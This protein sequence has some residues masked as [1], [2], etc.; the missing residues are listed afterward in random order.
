M[1]VVHHALKIDILNLMEHAFHIGYYERD[2]VF[3]ISPLNWKGQ[4]EF[5]KQQVFLKLTLDV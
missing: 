4:E 5:Q 1:L 2:K 3:Y